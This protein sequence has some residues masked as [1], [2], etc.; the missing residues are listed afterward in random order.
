MSRLRSALALVLVLSAS[1][2]AGGGAD[3]PPVPPVLE[4]TPEEVK[5]ISADLDK[6]FADK[7][8]ELIA[9]NLEKLEGLKNDAF[10]KYVRDGLKSSTPAV[11]AAAIRAAATYEMKDVEKDVRKLLHVKPAKKGD[12]PVE[13]GGEVAAASIDYLA[14]MN[15]GG[16]EATVLDDWLGPLFEF[17]HDDKRVG[18]SWALDLVRSSVHYLGKFKAKRAVPKLVELVGEPKHQPPGARGDINP[19]EPYWKARQIIWNKSGNWAR[20]ALKEITGQQF[21]SAQEW[22]AW[23]KMNKKDFK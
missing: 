22:E 6:S 10:A 8:D 7:N 14:R 13:S 4:P 9:V 3:A 20:W 2:L 17:F 21:Q 5:T 11:K 12:D 19:P 16:E 1:G 23:L 15:M 18:T